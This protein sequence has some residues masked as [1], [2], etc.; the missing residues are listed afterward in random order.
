MKFYP[1]DWRADPKLRMCSL[2]ARGLWAEMVCLMHEAKP[3]GS[4]LVNGHPVTDA[5]L[6]SLV[7]S[8]KKEIKSLTFELESAGVF[9]REDGIIISRRMKRDAEK[10]LKDKANGELGGNPDL[11]AGVNPPD[12]AQKL[13]ARDQIPEKKEGAN[14]PPA[15]PQ[16][17]EKKRA[18]TF[19]TSLTANRA[20]QEA[21][22]LSA[23]EGEREFARFR[24]HALS[25]GRT[26]IDWPAAERNWY[27]KAAEYLNK[28]IK[29]ES[30]IVNNQV[31]VSAETDAF[32]AWEAHLGKR[33]PINKGGWYFP[34]EYPPGHERA[35]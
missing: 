34:S 35:A 27:L 10:A 17:R 30:A 20:A 12:K 15:E 21:A 9:T 5:Q 31:F 7:G 33:P 23:A 1:S 29:T 4:L 18:T 32:R 16:K 25:R 8:T 24:N 11:K 28:P 3:Y 14:A 26:Y 6:A 13:E 22:G 19:P 2:A